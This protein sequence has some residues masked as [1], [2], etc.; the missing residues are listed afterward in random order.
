M[1]QGQGAEIMFE[2]W[3]KERVEVKKQVVIASVPV[4]G[5]EQIIN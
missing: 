1:E 3:V 5:Y 4:V 2:E